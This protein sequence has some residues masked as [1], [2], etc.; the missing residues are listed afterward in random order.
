[1]QKLDE[2]SLP[3]YR[4]V[5]MWSNHILSGSYV[6]KEVT[7]DIIMQSYAKAQHGQKE[8]KIRT[9]VS[10]AYKRFAR[11]GMHHHRPAVNAAVNAYKKKFGMCDLFNRQIKHRLVRR[12]AMRLPRR[13]QRQLCTQEKTPPASWKPWRKDS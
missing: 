7:D 13:R 10:N 9:A 6:D 12:Y 11:P 2:G 8:A 3:V 5:E 1:M 4:V